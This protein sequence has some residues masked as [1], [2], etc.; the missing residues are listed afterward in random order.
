MKRL[1]KPL[2]FCF[3]A[4]L[5]FRIHLCLDTPLEST[6]VLRNLG[7]A[8]HV[9]ERGFSIYNSAAREFAPE[10]WTRLFPNL[11]FPY[12]PVTLV[13][14]AFFATF[15]LGIFLAKL[16]LTLIELAIALTFVRVVS[17]VAGL[18]YFA[19]P[20]SVWFVSHEGQFEP[21]MA[22]FLCLAILLLQRGS[23]LYGAL[24][25]GLAAQSKQ[26]AVISAPWAVWKV[27]SAAD[28]KTALRRSLLGLAL[29]SLPF[30][31]F[32][33]M[34]PWMP[35]HPLTIQALNYNPFAWNFT[36]VGRF[37]WNPPWLIQ[38]NAVSSYLLLLVPLLALSRETNKREALANY[39]P[40]IL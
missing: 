9:G 37:S 19:M 26:L 14:F 24:A 1:G 5:A 21:L 10:V 16:V 22:G 17:P 30:L 35:T 38:W 33:A 27:W 31:G 18:A 23:W 25:W 2:T 3:L 4:L 20:V 32:Y 13:F 11:T 12:P 29:S 6:D 34:S 40:W 7:Y 8:G 39:S 28:R 36:D 15:G